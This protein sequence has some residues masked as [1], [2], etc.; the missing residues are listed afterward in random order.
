MQVGRIKTPRKYTLKLNFFLSK[1]RGKLGNLI[2]QIR[3]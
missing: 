3:R 2:S 1:L